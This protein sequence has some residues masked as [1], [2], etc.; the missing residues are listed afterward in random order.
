MVL[1][2]SLLQELLMGRKPDVSAFEPRQSDAE[3]LRSAGTSFRAAPW[4]YVLLCV[5]ILV[6][7]FG[8]KEKEAAAPAAPPEVQ[9]SEV[10]TR[11]VPVYEDSVSQ[12]NGPVNADITPKVQGYLLTQNYV[13]GSFV[14][15]GQLLFTIDSRPFEAA[16]AEAKAGVE[17][18]AAALTKASNDVQRSTPLAAQ[19]AIPQKQLDDDKA[20]QAWATAQLSA[21]KAAQ[22]Q[23]VLNLGWTKVY[24]PVDGIAGVANSQVGDLVGT[25]TK[26]AT[27]SEIDPIWAYFNV[28]ESLYLK[29]APRIAQILRTGRSTNPPLQVEYIQA[30]DEHYPA[31]GRII[32]VNREV[33]AGTGTIQMAAAFPNKDGILR[34]G[35]FG[36]VRVQTGTSKDAMLVPQP[37]VIEVQSQHQIIV[38]TADNKAMIRPVKVGDRVGPNWIITDGLKPGDRVVVEGIQRVQAA[39]AA[40]QSQA[41]GG[42]P[43]IVK[44]YVAAAM[45][46]G[47]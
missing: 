36:K 15:K 17:R 25:T 28:S 45:N 35:G 22:E 10:T 40:M 1:N 30:N 43:V 16:L 21:S 4:Y 34:P 41:Q 29:F 32:F 44:P 27:V 7:L 47:N 13:N 26:M 24:S 39:A 19:D 33:T 6:V 20:N 31:K 37:S 11:D 8:C 5:G 12:L 23:A 18:S 14:H 42:V 2:A 38:V 9:V 3:S 46:G